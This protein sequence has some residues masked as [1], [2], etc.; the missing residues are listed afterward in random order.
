MSGQVPA[1]GRHGGDGPAVAAALG[2]D[3]ASLLDLS[4]SLNPLAPDPLPVLA[5]HLESLRGYPDCGTAEAVLAQAI[6]AE[7]DR[8]LLTNGG[9]E[10]IAIVAAELGGSVEE[11]EFALH[12]RGQGP[13]WRSNPHNPSGL[14][15]RTGE[16]AGVW[17]EAFYPLAAGRWTRGD[18]DAV[19]VGSLTKLLAC[20]GLRAGYVLADP[21]VIAV[22]RQRQPEWSV[23]G[24]VA[25][26][27]PEL[28]ARVELAAWSAGVASL[29]A[30]LTALL[31][32][33]GLTV[34]RS[35]ACWVLVEHGG[36]RRLL[37][38]HG[39]LV[40]DCSSF[41]MPGVTRVA[42]P[43]PAGLER[44]EAALAHAGVGPDATAAPGAAGRAGAAAGQPREAGGR[45]REAGGRAGSA[46][47][48]AP[49]SGGTGAGALLV[50]GTSSG[51]GKTTV[52]A[53]LC[54]AMARRGFAVAPFKAQNMSLNSYVTRAGEEIARAQ[55]SQAHAAGVE[56]EAAMN[57]VLLKP[58]SDTESH[59]VVM[60]RPVGTLDARA[61]WDAKVALLDVVLD[62]YRDLRRRFDMVLCEGAG[63][64][65]EIN[66][67]RS[68]I[69]N[70]G[71]ARAAGVPA[72]LVGDID[73][74]GV[75]AAFAGTLALLSAE[76][77]GLV[78][79]F[80]VNRFRGE[81]GLL[82]PA[83][84]AMPA[85]TG[86]PVLGV[87]PFVRGLGLDAEDALDPDLYR[88]PAPPLGSDVLRIGVVLLPHASN[89]TDLDPLA[90]EPGVIVRFVTRPA[91]LADCDLAVLPGTRTT[92]DDLAWLRQRGFE[93]ALANRAAGGGAILGICGGYQMLGR[94]IVDDHES[95]AG[96]VPGL[97]LLP[98]RTL[99]GPEKVLNRRA[100]TLP[101]GSTVSGYEIHHG[102]VEAEGGTGFVAGEGC[103]SGQLAGT[104]WHGVFESDAFRRTYLAEVAAAAGRAFLPSMQLSYGAL[105]EARA[106]AL[107]D[108]VDRHLDL[109][110]IGELA[111]GGTA[112]PSP[113][114]MSLAVPDRC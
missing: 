110:R 7:R 106:D 97:G 13:R 64:P 60:G 55:A 68:D 39:V 22:C 69:V 40:R 36:L 101:D 87:L 23:N 11:P 24:L 42:V 70:L 35:D 93:A 80:V 76:D 19:V 14:L 71:F 49:R 44:L 30:E 29:R 75:F 59:L 47:A 34:R 27:L 96:R 15:A 43:S 1:P 53:G 45:V 81:V 89:L 46:G 61:G 8:L 20:P 83:L 25:A 92:V 104:T 86:R 16:R 31:T 18:D 107:A 90:C 4:Q 54:R 114:V 98:V 2:L 26:A 73:R 58:G 67:R 21:A 103:R 85:L 88:H 113:V 82:A 38:P 48:R 78:R 32:R 95:R 41:G 3:P 65:A 57:P 10:A 6:G 109:D 79:G 108:L 99:F 56:P 91:E 111:L 100:A 33:Y 66:L 62:A 102:R 72:I 112:A 12:P 63:S 94:E 37:A 51:A 5:R 105:R 9:S 17:D 28:L 74:G 77:Q 84:E 50:L 52:V